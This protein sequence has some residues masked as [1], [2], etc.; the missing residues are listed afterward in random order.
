M[1]SKIIHLSSFYLS[2]RRP[3][4]DRLRQASIAS[5]NS[6]LANSISPP[7]VRYTIDTT[8]NAFTLSPV[9]RKRSPPGSMRAI[10]SSG[11]NPNLGQLQN[12]KLILNA[13]PLKSR[14]KITNIDSKYFLLYLPN[15]F[16]WIFLDPHDRIFEQE[17]NIEFFT[18]NTDQQ[19]TAGPIQRRVNSIFGDSSPEGHYYEPQKITDD[20]LMDVSVILII[21][22]L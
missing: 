11:S 10:Q 3:S 18:K 22:N 5:S 8:V 1:Y 16:S 20:T 14:P 13:S 12:S 2:D 19:T 21:I 15:L 9:T 4:I 7:T 17:N 6:D